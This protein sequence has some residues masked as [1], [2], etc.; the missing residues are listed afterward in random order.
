[1]VALGLLFA[2]GSVQAQDLGASLADAE[3]RVAAAEAELA[4]EQQRVDE[5]RARYRAASRRAVAPVAHLNDASAEVARLR[6]ALARKAKLAQA[7]I[8]GLERQH[9]QEENEHDEDVRTGMGFGLA[10]LVAAL[11]ALS[12]GWFRATAPVAALARLEL[13]QAIGVCVGGGLLLVIVGA[14]LGSSNGAVGALGSFIFCLGLILPTAFLLARHSAE[15]Q[16]GRSRPLL[17]RERLPAWTSLATAA[18]MFVLFLAGAGSALFADDA[19]S[20]PISTELREEAAAASEGPGAE[21]VEAAR[22]TLA[23]A[24]KRAAGPVAQREAAQSQLSDARDDLQGTQSQLASARSDQRSFS[25]QLVAQEAKEE[26]ETERE[27]ELIAIEEEE[28]AEQEEE[29]EEAASE[30]DPSYSG[31]L[32]PYSSDYDCASGSGDGPDYTGTVEVYGDD[33]YGLDDDGDGIG[34]EYG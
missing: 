25:R 7:R 10:A 32:D 30:C 21:Q 17:R 1:L 29:E 4:A 27:A 26:R 20:N 12:W 14:V 34:C 2:C 6:R 33:H 22:K 18:L 28:F 23:A 9:Q 3:Q 24:K 16:R 11:I 13:G 15:V 19:S 8:A 31:C 5:A